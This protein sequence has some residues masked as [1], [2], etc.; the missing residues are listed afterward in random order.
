VLLDLPLVDGTPAVLPVRARR[1]RPE[2]PLRSIGAT[3]ARTYISSSSPLKEIDAD[4]LA[5]PRSTYRR[6]PRSAADA[7]RR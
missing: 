6:A 4:R 5:V 2:D 1:S 7:D 3:A